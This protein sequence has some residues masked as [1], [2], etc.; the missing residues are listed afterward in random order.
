MVAKRTSMLDKKIKFKNVCQAVPVRLA[1]SLFFMSYQTDWPKSLSYNYTMR[2]IGYDSIQTRWFIS[3]RIQTRTIKKLQ[4]HDAIYRLLFYS[5]SLIDI[6]SL[7][8]S[9]NNVASIQK[10]RGDKSHRVIVALGRYERRH[11]VPKETFQLFEKS[12][13]TEVTIAAILEAFKCMFQ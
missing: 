13:T 10:N 5:N 7:S 8:N 12:M 1:G 4:L 11:V 6:L 2:F 3:Y 9:H